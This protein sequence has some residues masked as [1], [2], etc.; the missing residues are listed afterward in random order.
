MTWE[1]TLFRQAYQEAKPHERPKYGVLNIYNAQTGVHAAVQYG[2]S[3]FEL[4]Y[5]TRFRATFTPK[6]S[7]AV[8]SDS[9]GT[10]EA[11]AHVM[12]EWEKEET[13]HVVEV[14]RRSLALAW[15]RDRGRD[16]RKEGSKVVVPLRGM[17]PP[18]EKAGHDFK[19]L[20]IHG[21]LELGRDMARLVV[22]PSYRK[23]EKRIEG[24]TQHRGA[25]NGGR[26]TTFLKLV[27]RFREK[28]KVP[29]VWMDTFEDV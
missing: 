20:Q 25:G 15:W 5:A 12:L 9:V 13:L 1:D 4:T 11:Y 24:G 28:H 8:K 19:E 16:R 29:V 6:D 26:G 17:H 21:P 23:K 10:V 2:K 3:Y 7:C 18:P 27:R 22:H 14:A